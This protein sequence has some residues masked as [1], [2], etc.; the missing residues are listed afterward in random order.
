MSTTVEKA[1]DAMTCPQCDGFGQE[2]VG[3]MPAVCRRCGGFGSVPSIRR[4]ATIMCGGERLEKRAQNDFDGLDASEEDMKKFEEDNSNGE[5][6][7]HEGTGIDPFAL[8][9]RDTPPDVINGWV[10][11]FLRSFSTDSMGLAY[12]KAGD[13]LG[14]SPEERNKIIE[15]APDKDYAV[16]EQVYLCNDKMTPS[17]RFDFMLELRAIY[18]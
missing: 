17:Q 16:K 12:E 6:N 15:S 4:F 10:E 3:A 1:S 5:D 13:I 7:A 14:I 8:L 18:S 11:S 9:S 2:D